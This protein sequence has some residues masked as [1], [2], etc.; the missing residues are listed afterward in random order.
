[1]H[2]YV[3]YS[4]KYIYICNLIGEVTHSYHM[5]IFFLFGRV[6]RGGRGDGG[7]LKFSYFDYNIISIILSHLKFLL[8]VI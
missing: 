7:V 6:E 4:F 5:L 1:M 8:R 2:I 3:R